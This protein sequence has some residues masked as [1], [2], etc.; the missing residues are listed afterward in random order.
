MNSVK[1]L[2]L[3]L[4]ALTLVGC[5]KSE[6]PVSCKGYGTFTPVPNYEN[7]AS[8]EASIDLDKLRQNANGVWDFHRINGKG[9]TS[10]AAW[11]KPGGLERIECVSGPAEQLSKL[12]TR[13]GQPVKML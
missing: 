11:I 7:A 3:F 10:Q 12:R 13:T 8:K 9:M 1:N 2:M 4:G 6:V 5:A